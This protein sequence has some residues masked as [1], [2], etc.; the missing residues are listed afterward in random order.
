MPRYVS[1][2]I[3][4]LM[5]GIIWSQGELHRGKAKVKWEDVCG[6]KIQGGLGIKS[7]QCWN[8]ALMSKHVWNIVSNKESL[9]VKWVNSYRL[10]DRRSCMRNF[11]DVPV[12]NDVCWGWKKILDVFEAGLS[13]NCKVADLV[14]NGEWR[15]PSVL[16][17]KFSFLI[18]LPPPLLFHDRKDKVLWKSNSYKI[19][20]FSIKVV[21]SDLILEK[22]IVPWFKVVWFSQNIPRNSFILWLAVKKKL[23]TQDR[24][25]LWVDKVNLRCPLCKTMQ[26]DHNHLFFAC[27]FS[28]KVWNFFKGLINLDR[29]PNDLYQAI[30]F[31]MARPVNKSIWSIIQRLVLGAVVYFIWQERNLRLFQGKG[32]NV[33]SLCCLIKDQVRYRLMSLRVK[34]SN[35]VAKAADIWNVQ[36]I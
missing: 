32:R 20:N 22:P 33:D 30:D 36:V 11:W 1:N 34:Y 2:E 26:D 5:K 10:S 25:A 9:W 17:D 6:L 19:C 3:E 8:V 16:S 35:Q 23:K 27:Q 29:A 12:L 21:W 31:I 13:L 24:L 4:K 14:V 7:L 18:H 28:S 15:W